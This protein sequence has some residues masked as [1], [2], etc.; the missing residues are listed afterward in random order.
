MDSLGALDELWTRLDVIAVD[1]PLVRRAAELAR[2]HGLRG[3]DAVHCASGVEVNGPD[4]VAVAGD[5]ALLDAW[6]VS[7]LDVIDTLA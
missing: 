6:R 2:A 7:G 4:T 5:R 3:Y 1:E